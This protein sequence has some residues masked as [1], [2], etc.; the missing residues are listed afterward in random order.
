MFGFPGLV[1]VASRPADSHHCHQRARPRLGLCQRRRLLTAS[2][3]IATR[4]PAPTVKASVMPAQHPR[5]IWADVP[6]GKRSMVLV[7]GSA[8][9]F[10]MGGLGRVPYRVR[11]S[12]LVSP[13]PWPSVTVGAA[14]LWLASAVVARLLL[15]SSVLAFTPIGFRARC[16]SCG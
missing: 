5:H 9:S 11:C 1:A 3:A 2:P 12:A 6:T 16:S 4:E 15:A 14:A 7:S 10:S 13:Q 8:A